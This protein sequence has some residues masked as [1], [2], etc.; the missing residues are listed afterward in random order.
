[1]STRRPLIGGMSGLGAAPGPRT[2][3]SATAQTTAGAWRSLTNKAEW[4]TGAPRAALWL[5]RTGGGDGS[6]LRIWVGARP[7]QWPA[8]RRAT[9]L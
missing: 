3:G 8:S 7:G 2:K 1:M 5:P 6:A 9:A 4:G